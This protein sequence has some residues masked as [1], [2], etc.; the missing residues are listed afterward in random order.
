[1]ALSEQHVAEKN[2]EEDCSQCSQLHL[3]VVIDYEDD[4]TKSTLALFGNSWPL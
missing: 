2:M 4:E 3:T 1:M